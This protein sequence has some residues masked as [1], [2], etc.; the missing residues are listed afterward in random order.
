MLKQHVISARQLAKVMGQ[1]ISMTKAIILG[2][3]LLCNVYRVLSTRSTWDSEVVLTPEA[4]KDLQWWLDATNGWNGVPLCDQQ[5][6]DCQLETD[7]S[8]FGWGGTVYKQHA[9]GL[10][11]VAMRFQHS[12]YRELLAVYMLFSFICVYFKWKNCS[13]FIRQHYYCCLPQPFR[14]IK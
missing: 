9:S 4:V 10:W 13:S 2:K 11:P 12:N 3:L 14:R 5:T 8:K 1:C 6:I 7:A